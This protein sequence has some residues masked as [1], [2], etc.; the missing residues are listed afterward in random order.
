M[1]ALLV[2]LVLAISGMASAQDANTL[3]KEASNLERQLKEAEALDKYKQVL[4]ID[5]NNM[6]AL[7]WCSELTSAAGK[8]QADKKAKKDLLEQAKQYADKALA[9]DSNNADAN[10]VRAVAALRMSEAETENKKLFQELKEIKQ[11][12]DK[13]LSIN[14]NHGRANYIEG[15]WNFIVVSMPAV[16]K[17]ALKI[18]YGSMPQAT[19]ENVYQYMEKCRTLEPYYVQN[20]LDLAKAY[21][22]DDK[23]AKAIEVLNQLVKLPN[24][25]ADDA[26]MKAEG[27][28]MLSEM[29]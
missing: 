12:A 23:P 14:P 25:T 22:Y 1:R 9:T 3:L 15:K 17:T 28:Q 21:K 16:K 8:R 4:A 18:F 26:A 29:Q 13:A 7:V 10:Y 27:K 5:A 6:Q 19:I 24:R 11:Y 2:A 20:F